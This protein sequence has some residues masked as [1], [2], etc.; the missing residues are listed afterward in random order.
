M[1]HFL[2]YKYKLSS[3]STYSSSSVNV[4]EAMLKAI[5]SYLLWT[6]A[7]SYAKRRTFIVNHIVKQKE[8][9][10]FLGT[11]YIDYQANFGFNWIFEI[12]WN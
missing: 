9:Y 10:P 8:E 1:E 11:F 3:E 5:A 2:A 6:Q 7:Q 12:K 4:R